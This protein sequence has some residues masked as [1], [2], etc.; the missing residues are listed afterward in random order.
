LYRALDFGTDLEGNRGGDYCR[1]CFRNGAFIEPELDLEDMVERI[2]PPG[3]LGKMEEAS[4]RNT[5]RG[6]LGNLARWHEE[7]WTPLPATIAVVTD[8]DRGEPSP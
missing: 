2:T 6:F 7:S 4:F 5:V 8:P 1:D 3:A